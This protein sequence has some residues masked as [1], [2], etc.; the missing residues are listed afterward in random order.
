MPS[1]KIEIVS[2]ETNAQ[3][4]LIELV[5]IFLKAEALG[6]TEFYQVQA[7]IDLPSAGTLSVTISRPLEGA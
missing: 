1:D 5:N 2:G 7:E 4:F 3:Q 6:I